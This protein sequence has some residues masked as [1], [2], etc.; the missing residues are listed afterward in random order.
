MPSGDSAFPVDVVAIPP[1]IWAAGD[2][3]ELKTDG[4]W[5]ALERSWLFPLVLA[6]I[7]GSAG[8][9]PMLFGA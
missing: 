5:P 3:K 4:N 8:L 7:S 9:I 1:G 2:G 6:V